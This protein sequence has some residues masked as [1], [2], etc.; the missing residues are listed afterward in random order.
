MTSL[1][2]PISGLIIKLAEIVNVERFRHPIFGEKS[3][4]GTKGE[5]DR[6]PFQTGNRLPQF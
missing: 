2:A 4:V 6:T 1:A 3:A 5:H